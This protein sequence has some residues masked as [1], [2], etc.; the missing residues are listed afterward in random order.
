[1]TTQG[2]LGGSDTTN[3]A[4]YWSLYTL[5]PTISV[6]SQQAGL[7]ALKQSGNMAGAV[8]N[9]KNIVAF[10]VITAGAA[11]AINALGG[12]AVA[13]VANEAV[14]PAWTAYWTNE[15]VG[16]VV[17]FTLGAIGSY[18]PGYRPP[19]SAAAWFGRA[20][21]WVLRQPEDQW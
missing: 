11:V 17:D 15:G 1:V 20:A 9:G 5:G 13:D 8:I 16:I 14:A 18:G 7:N 19:N 2:G 4:G 6:D 10:Y 3:Y 12:G 21:G